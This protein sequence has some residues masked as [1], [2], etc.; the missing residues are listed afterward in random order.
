[1]LYIFED[2]LSIEFNRIF[3]EKSNIYTLEC[4]GPSELFFKALL[5]FIDILTKKGCY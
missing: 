1:M 5:K 3:T 2:S 4:G